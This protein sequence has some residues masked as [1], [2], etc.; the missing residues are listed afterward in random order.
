MKHL[1]I[2]NPH[3]GK[4][5][6]S[7]LIPVIDKLCKERALD[8]II[9]STS[10][11]GDATKIVREYTRQE[12]MRVYSVGGDGTV[13]EV[14]NGIVNTNSSLAIIPSGSGN[15]F[16]RNIT[17]IENLEEIIKASIDG[18]TQWVDLGRLNDKYFINISSVGLDAEIV[19]TAI[20]LKKLPFIPPKFAY[21]LSIF[22]TVF[23][24]KSKRLKVIMDDVEVD[25]E[26]LLVAI[27]NGK[28]YGGGMKVSPMSDIS[29]G[30]F[31]ICHA[32]KAGTFKILRLFPRLIKGVHDS[33]KEV[34]FYKS[35]KVRIISEVELS[36]NI[37]GE[38][39]RMKNIDFEIIPRAIN[40]VVTK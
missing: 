6:T 34:T 39:L 19:Y 33:I 35:K 8:Y 9:K 24:Y 7:S 12:D 5:R 21:L 17:N 1:F 31:D 23:G 37:D 11:P 2:V 22:I 16:V 30:Y 20:K 25:T 4:G 27:A 38:L 15:D 36:V 32:R 14:V 13:N 26:T 28:Y 3:A 10:G 29:D 40:V 18:E